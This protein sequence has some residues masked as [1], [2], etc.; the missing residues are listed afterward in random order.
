MRYEKP[1]KNSFLRYKYFTK[2]LCH[3]YDVEKMR[4]FVHNLNLCKA[5]GEN[6]KVPFFS[7]LSDM[8]DIP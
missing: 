3:K 4:N 2:F 1:Q 6:S 8:T 5:L 7:I